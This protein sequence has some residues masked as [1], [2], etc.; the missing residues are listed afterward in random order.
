[1]AH[2][3]GVLALAGAVAPSRLASSGTSTTTAPQARA[4]SA[5]SARGFGYVLEHVREDAQ[6]IRPVGDRQA[7][8]VVRATTSICG[9]SRAI[10]DGRLGDLHAASRPPKPRRAARTAARRRRSRPRACS[11]AHARARA[12]VDHV[13][14]LADRAERSPARVHG[15]LGQVLRVGLVVEADQLGGV[16]PRRA[17]IVGS[18]TEGSA[19]SLRAAPRPSPALA[20]VALF[21]V[22]A[23]GQAG[24][25]VTHWAPG[26]LIVLALLGWRS[27]W[28]ACVR[29]R[30]RRR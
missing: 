30:C 13:I 26:G 8:A 20:A 3:G 17:I 6:V 25:P 15:R 27:A 23:T 22:W 11:R 5:S 7:R 1:M 9:R 24:Y 4:T 16:A 2:L 28:S 12:Q 21:V 14:G 10:V 18:M 19:A 29:P